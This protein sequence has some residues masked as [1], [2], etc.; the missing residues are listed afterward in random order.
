MTDSEGDV[1][2]QMSA[3]VIAVI[4]MELSIFKQTQIVDCAVTVPVCFI[5]AFCYKTGR[6]TRLPEEDVLCGVFIFLLR[7]QP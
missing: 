1:W 2:L 4:D 7:A 5:K 3:E 6:R